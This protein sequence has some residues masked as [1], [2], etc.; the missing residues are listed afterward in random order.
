MDYILEII[1]VQSDSHRAQALGGD[2]SL[3]SVPVVARL[4]RRVSF[5]SAQIDYKI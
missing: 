3:S 4:H 5:S 1:L 2:L